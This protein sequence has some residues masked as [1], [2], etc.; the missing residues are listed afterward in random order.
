MILLF[1][2]LYYY[3]FLSG[4]AKA[5]SPKAR[6]SPDMPAN[7]RRRAPANVQISVGQPA[8]VAPGPISG[9]QHWRYWLDR[10]HL[11]CWPDGRDRRCLTRSIWG[12]SVALRQNPTIDFS[13]SLLLPSGLPMG[14]IFIFYHIIGFRLVLACFF[15][16][17]FALLAS[18]LGY[19][20]F[21]DSTSGCLLLGGY[22]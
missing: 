13:V 21:L 22:N 14:S 7:Q 3:L 9:R 19:Q 6:E 17:F 5:L 12:C 10:S 18:I 2:L 8:R 11:P 15:F 4:N 20:M 16:F 1:L